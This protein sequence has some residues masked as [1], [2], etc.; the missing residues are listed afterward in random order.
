[1]KLV[2]LGDAATMTIIK[3]HYTKYSEPKTTTLLCETKRFVRRRALLRD[4]LCVLSIRG[5]I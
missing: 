1:M 4:N 2:G 3:D 5:D